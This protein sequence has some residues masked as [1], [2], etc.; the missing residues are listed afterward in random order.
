MRRIILILMIFCTI[1]HLNA[2]D[3]QLINPTPKTG[4]INLFLQMIILGT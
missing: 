1:N 4:L 2:Q 3:W